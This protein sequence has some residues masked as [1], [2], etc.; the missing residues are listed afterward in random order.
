MFIKEASHREI[1]RM[2]IIFHDEDDVPIFAFTVQLTSIAE[3]IGYFC[4]YVVARHTFICDIATKDRK[5]EKFSVTLNSSHE[6][7]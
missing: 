3:H 1:F 7:N 2:L 6:L 5:K 4:F